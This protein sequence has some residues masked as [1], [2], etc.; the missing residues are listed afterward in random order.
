M[1]GNS[2]SGFRHSFFLIHLQK[3]QKKGIYELVSSSFI[4]L[5]LKMHTCILTIS[6]QICSA[7]SSSYFKT[8]PKTQLWAVLRSGT[9]LAEVQAGGDG[10]RR[11]PV[12]PLTRRQM[13][14]M[15]PAPQGENLSAEP[16]L[17]SHCQSERSSRV[18]PKV[19]EGLR[20]QNGISWW[21]DC[22]VTWLDFWD[23]A[24][25]TGRLVKSLGFLGLRAWS[26]Q[27]QQLIFYTVILCCII[28]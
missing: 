27:T 12:H 8:Q 16:Q 17:R 24:I 6:V 3:E 4:S 28:M 23:C 5:V 25:V 11:T 19:G 14:H 22:N 9:N 1:N 21:N 13:V 10:E 2:F 7:E 20:N 26:I 15:A 18:E